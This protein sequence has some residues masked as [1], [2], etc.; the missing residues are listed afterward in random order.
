MSLHVWCDDKLV[1][2]VSKNPGPLLHFQISLTN[3]GHGPLSIIFDMNNLQSVSNL[4]ASNLQVLIKQD[5]YLSYFH[6][7]HL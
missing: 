6:D 5:T 7:N 1:Y 2:R 4:V 3:M